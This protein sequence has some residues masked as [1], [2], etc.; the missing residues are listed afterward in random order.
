[1]ASSRSM[2]VR[3]QNIWIPGG[4]KD[5]DSGMKVVRYL[6]E[7]RTHTISPACR[8]SKT[9]HQAAN[10]TDGYRLRRNHFYEARLEWT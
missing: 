1:M 8:E 7:A 9:I 2:A 5:S 10:Y 3:S 6:R 4:I